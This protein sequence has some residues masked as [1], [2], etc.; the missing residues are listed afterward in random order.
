M[1]PRIVTTASG[2]PFMSAEQQ[3]EV[4]E[5]KGIDMTVILPLA[6]AEA[7]AEKASIAP[8]AATDIF[9]SSRR[10]NFI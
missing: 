1:D 3:L 9:M 4:M 5:Q 2:T 7:P 8:P 10:V 6:S